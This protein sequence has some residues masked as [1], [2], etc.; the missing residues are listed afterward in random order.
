MLKIKMSRFKDG[1]DVYEHGGPQACSG[2][3]AR[4]R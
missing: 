1:G 3:F 4:C 2:E